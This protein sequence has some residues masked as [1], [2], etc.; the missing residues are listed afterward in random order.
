MAEALEIVQELSGLIPL[1]KIGL[2][3]FCAEG[4]STVQAVRDAGAEVFL[5]LKVHDIPRTAAAAV[6]EAGRIGAAYLTIHGFGGRDMIRA[7]AETSQEHGGPQLLVVTVLT[8]L[9]DT[10][11][12]EVGVNSTVREHALRI[13][14]LAA[15]EG[16]GGLVLSPRELD[17][18]RPA[19][20]HLQ[21]CTPG[22]R[23][24]GHSVHDHQR[25]LTPAEAVLAG[26]DLLV[27]GRPVLQAPDRRA[28]AA[29]IVEQVREAE[30]Q[31]E[32][33]R[34]HDSA[35]SVQEAEDAEFVQD[36]Q[37]AT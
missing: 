32:G 35:A 34:P 30:G 26:A 20:P 13:G 8:S 37:G 4:T 12:A 1:F 29:A 24:A 17:V 23:P 5:D 33:L 31:R 28:A 21:L 10:R 36:G 18:V 19:L 22:V 16:A 6:R 9:D 3:L 14:R 2:E 15:E 11:L 25:S 7:A 27:V